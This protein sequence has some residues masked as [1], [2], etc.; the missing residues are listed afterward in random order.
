M[1]VQSPGSMGRLKPNFTSLETPGLALVVA[2]RVT[3][4][5][6]RL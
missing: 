4:T 6:N 1:T 5:V 2:I 3:Y